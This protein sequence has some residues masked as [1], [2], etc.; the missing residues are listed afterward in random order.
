MVSRKKA[1]SHIEIQDVQD[2]HSPAMSEP[3]VFDEHQ[4]LFHCPRDGCT[5]VFRRHSALEKHLSLEKCSL[6]LERYSLFDLAK[7]GYQSRL[8]AGIGTVPT[9]MACNVSEGLVRGRETLNE[10][11]SLRATKK[12]YR[13]SDHQKKYLDAKFE[14]GRVTGRKLNG[15][16][17]ARQMRRALDADGK[18]LFK[19]SEFL[20]QQQISSYFSRLAAKQRR[21]EAVDEHDVLAYEEEGNFS[22]TRIV[23]IE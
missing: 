19:V 10:G 2:S 15:E 14:I 9:L 23:V 20:S 3:T 18:R 13:F 5:R 4:S 12:S 8:A 6:S 22:D 1:G 17:V 21:G 16:I 7:L 11:W